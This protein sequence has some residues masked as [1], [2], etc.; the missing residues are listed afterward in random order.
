MGNEHRS[1][2]ELV[3]EANNYEYSSTV[4]L[5]VYLR[6][7]ETLNRHA[8]LFYEGKSYNDAFILYTRFLNL[9]MNKIAFNPQLKKDPKL[10]KQY[11]SLVNDKAP[12]ALKN[13]EIVKGHI[14]ENIESYER[15]KAVL[16]ENKKEH[17]Q[18]LKLNE[19]RAALERESAQAAAQ[20]SG[21]EYET[22]Q[23]DIDDDDVLD[24]QLDG[25]LRK[26]NISLEHLPPAAYPQLPE[27]RELQVKSEVEAP[28]P[29]LPSKEALSSVT[30]KDNQPVLPL[31]EGALGTASSL[32]S[33]LPSIAHSLHLP[34]KSPEHKI[35]SFTEAGKPLKTVYLPTELQLKFLEV[36]QPNTTKRLETCG[37][38]CGKLSLNAFFITTL[39]I[40]EQESTE[41]TCQTNDEEALFDYVDKNDLFVLGWIHTHPTQSCFLS[42]VD[43]HT[44]NSYQIMLPEAMAIVCAPT[45]RPNFGIFRLSDPPGIGIVTQC[46]RTGFHPHNESGI[47]KRAERTYGGHVVTKKDLPFRCVDLRKKH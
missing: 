47:Y 42:S 13:A 31:K 1:I 29:S 34:H 33:K 14:L 36:A 6:T 19:R 8:D 40:P 11:L 16:E 44:Q 9:L 28:P 46:H 2:Q 27:H 4:P 22:A 3:R 45:A 7:A 25:L 15:H 30:Y 24:G 10:Y 12:L 39:V 26:P 37:I 20:S 5:R 35:A 23:S 43:L 41:N 21:S 38:L 18:L 17:S 32:S